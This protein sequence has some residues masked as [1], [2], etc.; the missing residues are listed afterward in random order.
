MTLKYES[1]EAIREALDSVPNTDGY[2]KLLLEVLYLA[3]TQVVE[4]VENPFI[5]A[6]DFVNVARV[7]C[8]RLGIDPNNMQPETDMSSENKK[9]FTS[10]YY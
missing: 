2:Q 9:F 5:R 4:I 3:Q 6:T 10:E 1:P 7:A 8:K